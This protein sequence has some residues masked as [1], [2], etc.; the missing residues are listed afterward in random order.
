MFGVLAQRGEREENEGRTRGE[1]EENERSPGGRQ[2][3]PVVMFASL[4]DDC[5][6]TG[7]EWLEIQKKKEFFVTL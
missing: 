6:A 2:R 5:M 4:P 7:P 3:P 1:R